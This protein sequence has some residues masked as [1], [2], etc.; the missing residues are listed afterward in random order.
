M[1]GYWDLV[2]DFIEEGKPKKKQLKSIVTRDEDFKEKSE[3]IQKIQNMDDVL[4]IVELLKESLVEWKDED[5]KYDGLE[6]AIKK[7]KIII[8]KG[9]LKKK[10]EVNIK[11]QLEKAKELFKI[12]LQSKK[13]KKEEKVVK[14][15]KPKAEPFLLQPLYQQPVPNYPQYNNPVEQFMKNN[16]LSDLPQDVQQNLHILK[17][18]Y[19]DLHKPIQEEQP[20]MIQPQPIQQQSQIVMSQ[21]NRGPFGNPNLNNNTTFSKLPDDDPNDPT[22]ATI[23]RLAEGC[24]GKDEDTGQKNVVKAI[25]PS[26][27]QTIINNFTNDVNRQVSFNNCENPAL[28]Y[29][30]QQQQPIGSWYGTNTNQNPRDPVYDFSNPLNNHNPNPDGYVWTGQQQVK[31]NIY[32]PTGYNPSFD[33]IMCQ[34]PDDWNSNLNTAHALAEW[35][36]V[37]S[38]NPEVKNARTWSEK[39]LAA[40][41]GFK[42]VVTKV[43]KKARKEPTVDLIMRKDNNIIG[44]RTSEKIVVDTPLD[45]CKEDDALLTTVYNYLKVYDLILAELVVREMTKNRDKY[46][47]EDW[48]FLEKYCELKILRYQTMESQDPYTDYRAPY[49]FRKIP[50]LS[51]EVNGIIEYKANLEKNVEYPKKD[52]IEVKEYTEEEVM[53]DISRDTIINILLK[54]SQEELDTMPKELRRTYVEGLNKEL[55]PENDI[56]IPEAPNPKKN[57]QKYIQYVMESAVIKQ[58][59]FYWHSLKYKFRD[60]EAF[61]E[62]FFGTEEENKKYKENLLRIERNRIRRELFDDQQLNLEQQLIYNEKLVNYRKSWGV[63]N[64][65]T[66]KRY[67]KPGTKLESISQIFGALEFLDKKYKEEEYQKNTEEEWRKIEQM[68]GLRQSVLKGINKILKKCHRVYPDHFPESWHPEVKNEKEFHNLSPKINAQYQAFYNVIFND[69]IHTG[70]QFCRPTGGNHRVDRKR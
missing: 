69:V 19:D 37:C 32:N 27:P 38:E 40:S 61:S 47:R 35:D 56:P 7:A 23:K 63:Y 41:K 59:N 45:W 55:L 42:F 57:Q 54:R 44:K 66:D 3:L 36:K 65:F 34:T 2:K 64:P 68:N 62:W 50:Y 67:F 8:R 70:L 22:M 4:K 21:F 12:K 5:F 26:P 49:R 33:D 46:S 25:T 39:V 6:D 48:I 15:E 1:K 30:T 13:K 20:I 14:P 60:K 43:E 53:K 51:R 52:T 29:L 28:A 24:W 16:D 18:M 58:F 11:E 17:N 31:R 9:K 10:K